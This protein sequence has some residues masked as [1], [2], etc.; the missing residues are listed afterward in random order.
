MM[1]NERGYWHDDYARF[2]E[3]PKPD[4]TIRDGLREPAERRIISI[5]PGET[6]AIVKGDGTPV[7]A[8]FFRA[9]RN[10]VCL[11]SNYSDRQPYL[12]LAERVQLVTADGTAVAAQIWDTGGNGMF[13][14][15]TLP[16]GM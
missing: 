11:L 14:L 16:A 7:A 5:R 13:I 6:V 15:R 9:E 12:E 3:S 10:R 2:Q 4:G 1:M 8:E